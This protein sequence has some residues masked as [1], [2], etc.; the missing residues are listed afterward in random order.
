MIQRP[1]TVFLLLG[2]ALLVAFAALAL[3]WL[4]GVAT[5]TGVYETA[6]TVVAALAAVVALGAVFLYKDRPRQRRVIGIAQVLALVS[7]VPLL[8]GL[9][10][11]A[12]GAEDALMEETAGPYLVALL[13]IVAYVLL[14]MARRGVDRDIA[15]VRSM[16]RLR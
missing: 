12:P 5:V 15:T 1:Q 3:A 16:D 8:V 7:V 10:Q 14:R 11:A 13:P 9:F 2:A 6:T 4:P